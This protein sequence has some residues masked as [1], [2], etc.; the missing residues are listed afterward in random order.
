MRLQVVQLS[1]PSLVW[2]P[3]CVC[4]WLQVS[5]A[6]LFPRKDWLLAEMPQFFSMCSPVLHQTSSGFF[7]GQLLES[8]KENRRSHSSVRTQIYF[9]NSLS[10]KASHKSSPDLRNGE[11]DST[12]QWKVLQSHIAKGCWWRVG[13]LWPSL[14]SLTCVIKKIKGSNGKQSDRVRSFFVLGQR[15]PL[16]RDKIWGDMWVIRNS[17]NASQIR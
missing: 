6:A 3:S 8:K 10:V 16:C 4:N 9:Q 5:L 7:T 17:S 2:V 11:I 12:S 1:R 15:K 13:K 14:E